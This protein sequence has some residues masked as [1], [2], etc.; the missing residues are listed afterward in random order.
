MS[1]N[2]KYIL[3]KSTILNWIFAL[4]FLIYI[5]KLP[6]DV[7]TQPFI[8]F[9]L[10]ILF[11][12]VNKI[13]VNFLDS[14]LVVYVFILTCYFSIQ[15]IT[16]R[17]GLIA[18]A[19]YLVGPVI[20]LVFKN[21][22]HYLS[23]KTVKIFVV[24]FSCLAIIISLK[25]P[26]LYNIVYW[27]YSAVISRPDWIDGGGARGFTLLAPEPSYFSFTAVLLLTIIDIYHHKGRK[28]NYYKWAIIII[29]VLSK[30]ALVFL[31]VFLYLSITLLGDKPINSLKR[32]PKKTILIFSSIILIALIPFFFV[33]SRVSEV[34]SNIYTSLT[35]KEGLKKII[36][37]EVSGTTRFIMNTFAFLSIE[38]VPFGWG[39]GQFPLHYKIIANN[40]PFI[41]ENHWEF[42]VAYRDNKPMKAQTYFANIFAD[43]GLFSLPIFLFL[44]LSIVKRTEDKIKR[45]L[46]F[47]IPLMLL[48]VQCQISN[49]IPWILL[50]VVNT[51]SELLYKNG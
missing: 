8:L 27:F 2:I 14:I 43:I 23:I 28:N 35:T 41:V 51:K 34:F 50:A 12:L 17:T 45:A 21:N 36:V 16:N 18:Y 26:V 19:S 48:F 13:K 31:Y 5:K 4:C 37:T 42:I 9:F 15:F 25:I 29:A 47:V 1:E 44:F 38:Y 49:P 6:I 30:S 11:V 7:E 33:E 46:Q 10:G 20:Y 32:I 24:I 22:I 40:F 39:I 3:K